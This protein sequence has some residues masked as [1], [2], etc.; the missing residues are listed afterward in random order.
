MK[1][2]PQIV[3]NVIQEFV[4]KVNDLLGD[5]VKKI[6]LY[7]SYAR[8]DFNEES[9]IDIM[10]LTD[11]TDAEIIE[12][13]EKI[14]D[15]AYE[16]EWKNNFDIEKCELIFFIKINAYLLFSILFINQNEKS[17][18]NYIKYSY[19]NSSNIIYNNI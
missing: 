9:D 10:I 1:K 16:I 7:G 11:L 19:N 6:V 8:G 13:R 3:D 12:K 18:I 2:K 4:G 17:L 14:W 5:R 15:I